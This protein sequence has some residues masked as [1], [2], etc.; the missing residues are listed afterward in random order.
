MNEPDVSAELFDEEVLAINLKTGNY[1]SLRFSALTFW[2]LI[3]EGN[4]FENSIDIL[5]KFYSEK[6]ENLLLE[7]TSF[8][9]LLMD[10]SL[11]NESLEYKTPKTLEWLSSLKTEYNKPILE[12][13]SDMK[14]LLLIDPIHEVDVNKGWP[15]KSNQSTEK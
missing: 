14:D 7:F 8:L 10:S 4:S 12:S 11:I 9:K 5:S 13:Y 1:Y 15:N 2:R 6:E 3:T